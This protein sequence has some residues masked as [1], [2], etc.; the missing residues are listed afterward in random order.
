MHSTAP[1]ATSSTAGPA[2]GGTVPALLRTGVMLAIAAA[3]LAL[4]LFSDPAWSAWLPDAG[5]DFVT[6]SVSVFV[7]SL[8]FVLLGIGISILVQVW[9]PDR[10]WQRLLPRNPAGRRLLLSV[11]GV[12][13]PVCECGNVPL[14]RGLMMRGLGVGDALTFLLAAPVL[15]PVTII[16]TYQAFGFSDGILLARIG[17]AFLIANL[18]GWLFS[19]HPDPSALLTPEFEARCHAHDAPGAQSRAVRSARSFA[20]ETTTMLPALVAGSVLAG[21]IQVG[22][23][24]AILVDL[25]SN[26]VLSVLVLMLLAFVVAVCSNVDAFFILSFSATFMPGGVVA[27]LIFGA[28]IDIKML[29]LLRTTFTTRALGLIATLVALCVIVIGMGLNLVS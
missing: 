2:A 12:F 15:N 10:V 21:A 20:E 14:A 8:P 7:E 11:L 27:F 18:A 6:L 3:L 25:G 9:V 22:V 13:L 29:A 17:G 4:R 16:T 19:R 23:P 26:P 1:R 28:M 5:R 24:R